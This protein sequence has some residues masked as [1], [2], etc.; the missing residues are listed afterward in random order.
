VKTI[1][2]SSYPMFKVGDYVQHIGSQGNWGGHVLDIDEGS[3][4]ERKFTLRHPSG[5]TE[6]WVTC[7]FCKTTEPIGIEL[8][9]TKFEGQPPAASEFVYADETTEKFLIDC[10]FVKATGF[11]YYSWGGNAAGPELYILKNRTWAIWNGFTKEEFETMNGFRGWDL[12][13]FAGWMVH[14]AADLW[15]RTEKALPL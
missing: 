1:R 4:P 15:R 6:R 12:L 7:D 10:G 5:K 2:L 9:Y 3:E 13:H 14:G 8:Q 11:P